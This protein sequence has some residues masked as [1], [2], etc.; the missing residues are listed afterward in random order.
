MFLDADCAP[1]PEMVSAYHDAATRTGPALLCGP[2]AYLPPA[3]PGGYPASGLADLAKPHPAR[4]APAESDLIHRGDHR[5]FWSLSFAT[6]DSTWRTLGGFCERYRGYGAEDT[7]LG[8]I[9]RTRAIEL[10]W[11]GGA[12]AYHQHHPTIEPPTQHIDDI[13]RNA[14]IFHERWRWWPMRGWLDEFAARGL[15]TFDGRSWRRAV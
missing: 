15:V 7:D 9:A 14:A 8:Q 11:V 2:V 4:P 5:L 1:A 12:R 13:L 6:R 10:C 3:P